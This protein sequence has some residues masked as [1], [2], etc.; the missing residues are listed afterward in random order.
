MSNEMTIEDIDEL[1]WSLICDSSCANDYLAYVEQTSGRK[2]KQGQALKR[3]CELYY[4]PSGSSKLGLAIEAVRDLSS[5]NNIAALRTLARWHKFGFG[6]DKSPI[7]DPKEEKSFVV[8]DETLAKE[9]YK[10]GADLGDTK[11]M[12]ALAR[13]TEDE[14]QA[15]ACLMYER[16]TDLGDLSAHS[17]WA[18]LD[19]ANYL[20]HLKIGAKSNDPYC[21]YA[22]GYE[23][24]KSMPKGVDAKNFSSLEIQF[25]VD[26]F[27]DLLRRASQRGSGIAALLLSTKYLFGD[28][29]FTKDKDTA[30]DWQRLGA[31]LGHVGCLYYLGHALV[32]DKTVSAERLEEGVMH[33]LSGS[34]LGDKLCQMHLGTHWTLIGQSIEQKQR[35]YQWLKA[36]VDQGHKEAIFRLGCAIRDGSGVEKDLLKAIQT[37]R[38]GAEGGIALCQTSLGMAYYYGSDI[39]QDY[40][41]AFKWFQLASLQ[42]EP[43]AHQHLGHMYELG[44]GVE[45]DERRA[46]EYFTM[47]TKQNVSQAFSNLG[48]CYMVGAGV[49]EDQGIGISL[50][51]EGAALGNAHC[52]S[53]LGMMLLNGDGLLQSNP[54]LAATWFERAIQKEDSTAMRCLAQMLLNGNGVEQDSARGRNLMAKA[55]AL[56]DE[57]AQAW[58]KENLPKSPEWLVNLA[59][60]L[61]KEQLIDENDDEGKND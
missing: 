13:C 5:S 21:L 25:R 9:L 4:Q 24:E 59:S 8:Q 27:V 10:K 31:A 37:Y 26:E 46:V 48:W 52:M 7:G 32:T 19:K 41:Q 42:D 14:N 23:L 33:L 61:S 57:K 30:R 34:I 16:I 29:G 51:K 11:C 45:K 54:S 1:I 50:F 49:D 39:P 43:Y 36:S 18:D 38:L 12:I 53:S 40:K 58:L 56:G 15:E 3:A 44:H 17:Y 47:A 35:G 22:L 20:E 60:D 6:N 2:R 28:T 55:A